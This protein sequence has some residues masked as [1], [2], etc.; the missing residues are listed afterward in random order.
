MADNKKPRTCRVLLV[1]DDRNDAFLF[2]RAAEDAR[3]ILPLEIEL[4]HVDDGLAALYL[5]S[6]RDLTSRLPDA[7]IL[8][9]SMR[10]LDGIKFLRAV[11]KNTCDSK[12]CPCS[13]LPE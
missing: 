2:K 4:D 8:D 6:Q 1:E 9:L 11:R 5:V 12:T 3:R 7:V 13:C 10:R